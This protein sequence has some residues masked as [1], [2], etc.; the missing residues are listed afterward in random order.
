MSGRKYRGRVYLREHPVPSHTDDAVIVV[1]R[2]GGLYHVISV[3]TA[4]C[5]DHRGADAG[6]LE[7]GGHFVLPD[8][9]GCAV[10]SVWV[11][12]DEETAGATVDGRVKE[13]REGGEPPGD[14]LSVGVAQLYL[15]SHCHH[16]VITL[17]SHCHHTVIMPTFFSFIMPVC[18]LCLT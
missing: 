10:A 3:V 1:K 8:L 7:D 4:L 13:G 5:H 12:E 14:D 16:T 15:S 9:L 17:S 11:D 18:W 6:Y 2:G